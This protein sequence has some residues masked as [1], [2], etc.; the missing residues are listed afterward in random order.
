MDTDMSLETYKKA[1]D[2]FSARK[3]EFISL[4]G[5]EPTLHENIIEMLMLSFP[6]FDKVIFNT[7]GK[8]TAVMNKLIKLSESKN[9]YI[10]LSIDKYHEPIDEEVVRKFKKDKTQKLVIRRVV[11][12][13]ALQ[14]RNTDKT[15]GILPCICQD[16]IVQPNGDVALCG[17]EDAFILGNV[18]TQVKMPMYYNHFKC[19]KEYTL[20]I[21]QGL[22]KEEDIWSKE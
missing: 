19:T 11:S 17:C 14:G 16:L 5:G 1:L 22:F 21:E 3:K 7:N 20:R 18:H 10:N 8:G 15:G 9:L 4:S 13:L 2:F 6:K 12:D